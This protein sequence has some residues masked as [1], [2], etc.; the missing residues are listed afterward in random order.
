ML[1]ELRDYDDARD[2]RD[3]ANA[4]GPLQHC[5]RSSPPRIA[6]P[7]QRFFIHAEM[8]AAATPKNI[9]LRYAHAS[10]STPEYTPF[11]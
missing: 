8:M 6:R 9:S 7:S 5:A 1:R 11:L 3:V 2:L 10:I 4:A